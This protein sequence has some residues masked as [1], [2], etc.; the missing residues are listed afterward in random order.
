MFSV[1][2]HKHSH[3]CNPLTH[4]FIPNFYLQ[5]GRRL[6]SQEKWKRERKR[7]RERW[8]ERN[9]D[10]V[11]SLLHWHLTPVHTYTHTLTFGLSCHCSASHHFLH[12][13]VLCT[14]PN[15]A[16][17]ILTSEDLRWERSFLSGGKEGFWVQELLDINACVRAYGQN[18]SA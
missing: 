16:G 4:T 13:D 7:E 2:W 1:F 6:L 8:R 17:L 12:K 18:Y 11:V 14:K 10:G 15:I 3:M 5:M 9:S